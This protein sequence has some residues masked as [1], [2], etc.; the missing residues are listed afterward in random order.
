GLHAGLGRRRLGAGP[1]CG[2]ACR[3][4]ATTAGGRWR[5]LIPFVGVVLLIVRIV[6]A[7]AAR[8]VAGLVARLAALL[9]AV[10]QQRGQVD[11]VAAMPAA[12]A[13]HWLQR[14]DV[15]GL[16]GLDLH[17]DELAHGVGEGVAVGIG[18][19]GRRHLVDELRGHLQLAF[20]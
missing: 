1:G 19:P 10:A 2:A 8:L 14:L 9:E 16:A 18:L 12:T 15:G 4:A 11:D 3:F 20:L 5:C 6:A 13:F 7:L 17:L